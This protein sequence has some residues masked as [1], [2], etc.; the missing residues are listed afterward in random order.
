M[1]LLYAIKKNAL[2]QFRDNVVSRLR[3]SQTY[4]IFRKGKID[5]VFEAAIETDP[6]SHS[7]VVDPKKLPEI[8]LVQIR[9]DKAEV[10]IADRAVRDNITLHDEDV[11]RLSGS[12]T[13]FRI[14]W[15]PMVI[16]K[17]GPEDDDYRDMIEEASQMGFHVTRDWSKLV[18]HVWI[19]DTPQTEISRTLLLA[20]MQ[21]KYIVTKSWIKNE[22]IKSADRKFDYVACYKTIPPI[23]WKDFGPLKKPALLSKDERRLKLFEDMNFI[24]FDKEQVKTLS[25]LIKAACRT[26]SVREIQEV[27]I[28]FA[29]IYC[30]TEHMCNSA[31]S[32]SSFDLESLDVDDRNPANIK[33]EDY[34]SYPASCSMASTLPYN[35]GSPGEDSMHDLNNTMDHDH[36][37]NKSMNHD[38]KHPSQPSNSCQF[39]QNP[40]LDNNNDTKYPLG[41]LAA[42]HPMS[43]AEAMSPIEAMSPLGAT[44]PMDDDDDDD[45]S[46]LPPMSSL[47]NIFDDFDFKT[48]PL[49]PPKRKLESEDST[50][51]TNNASATVS[52]PTTPAVRSPPAPTV[53]SP[54]APDARSPIASITRSPITS[55]ISSPVVSTIYS[56]IA[57]NIRSPIA[58][59]IRELANPPVRRSVTP[60]VTTPAERTIN[61]SATPS[62]STSAATEATAPEYGATD[63]MDTDDVPANTAPN[64]TSNDTDQPIPKGRYSKIV[65]APLAVNSSPRNEPT[66]NSHGINYKKFKKVKQFENLNSLDIVNLVHSSQRTRE[67]AQPRTASRLPRLDETEDIDPF[68]AISVP[69]RPRG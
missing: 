41:S 21:Q 61:R 33:T 42:D 47:G 30:S 59:P 28:G 64:S 15:R 24:A 16:F 17:D 52:V 46:N 18:T 4:V 6:I 20:L 5:D 19:S 58:P 34:Y 14:R 29:I 12:N 49:P 40:S 69:R 1:W 38:H 8:R 37:S 65:Y 62:A 2:G 39:N 9:S 31:A 51:P 3:P 10:L 36:R 63:A 55:G 22:F 7:Q 54:T 11:I 67:R 53:R 32:L 56:P 57:S 44:S 26:G 48:K 45:D 35:A 43:L 13:R 23:E 25:S 66:Q 50:L 60:L 68:L 27:E